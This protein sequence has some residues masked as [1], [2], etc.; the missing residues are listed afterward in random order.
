MELLVVPRKAFTARLDHLTIKSMAPGHVAIFSGPHGPMLKPDEYLSV[1]V[2]ASGSGIIAQLS[3]LQ[4]LVQ[5]RNSFQG[6]TRS[7]YCVWIIESL[8]TIGLQCTDCIP[9]TNCVDGTRTLVEMVNS[10][11]NLDRK[12]RVGHNPFHL[13]VILIADSESCDSPPEC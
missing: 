4:R 13:A 3:F 7:L 5:A 12:H 2:I 8:G 6:M 10:I 9:L 11:L 1:L